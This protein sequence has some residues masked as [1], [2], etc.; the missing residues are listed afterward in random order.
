MGGELFGQG[1]CP[2]ADG[3][4]QSMGRRPSL[5]TSCPGPLEGKSLP[6]TWVHA[7][8]SSAGFLLG[9]LVSGM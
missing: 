1:E 3:G 9:S 4:N 6:G 2:G 7:I 8:H 5:K